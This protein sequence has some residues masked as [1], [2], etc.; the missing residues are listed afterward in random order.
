MNSN[1]LKQL[2]IDAEKLDEWINTHRRHLHQNPELSFHE[3]KTSAY[4]RKQVEKLGLKASPPIAEGKYGFYTELKSAKNP[5]T[6][7]LLRAD[8]DALPIQE[9]N[10]VDFQSQVENVGHLCGHDS[11][12]SMLLGALRLLKD[13]E[14][15]LPVSVRFVFQHAEEVAPG[16]ALDFVRAGVVDDVMGCF[17]IHVSPKLTTGQFGLCEG[18]AMAMVGTLSVTMKGR[19]GHAATPHDAA[20]PVVAS[21][22]AITALQQISSRRIASTEPIVVSVTTVHGG[23]A[24]NIIPPEV[25]FTGTL[26]TFE[27]KRGPEIIRL[28]KEIVENTARAYGCE[29]HVEAEFSYPPVVNNPLAL[30][31]SRHTVTE[32]FGEEYAIEIQKGMGAEDFAYF[33]REKPSSFVYIGVRKE[34]GDYYPLHHP[35]FLP[36][37]AAFWKGSALLAAMPFV[38]PEILL[39]G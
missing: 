34:G 30:K 13:R 3:E 12:T 5:D 11:H 28:I 8:M 39:H 22:A 27:E 14:N 18:T 24:F 16:G 4:V 37:S 15:E 25:K 38:A 19:A 1:H 17:G 29:A 26:R 21:A 35:Q 6:Y 32:M 10:Q 33:A 2:A 20:D 31:A 7:I 36:D 9:E 23:S